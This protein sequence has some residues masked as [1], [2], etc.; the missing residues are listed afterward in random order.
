M[1]S[2]AGGC[3]VYSF[4]IYVAGFLAAPFDIGSRNFGRPTI[5]HFDRIGRKSPRDI[6]SRIWV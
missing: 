6:K 4:T 2:G 3:K 5:K 1:N